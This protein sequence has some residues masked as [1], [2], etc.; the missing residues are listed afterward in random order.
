M[1]RRQW[2][3]PVF[4]VFLAVVGC[5]S[6]SDRGTSTSPPPPQLMLNDADDAATVRFSDGCEVLFAPNR[7]MVKWSP[8]CT[9]QQKASARRAYQSGL[10]E[11]DAGPEQYRDV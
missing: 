6:D 7:A 11:R 4:M 10:N 5:A 3:F 8:F 9:E 1:R 2:A